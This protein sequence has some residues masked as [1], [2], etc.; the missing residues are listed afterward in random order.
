MCKV[1]MLEQSVTH[2]WQQ[3]KRNVPNTTLDVITFHPQTSCGKD[4]NPLCQKLLKTYITLYDTHRLDHQKQM[5][6]L[7][8]WFRQE[9]L[10]VPFGTVVFQKQRGGNNQVCFLCEVVRCWH[11]LA[12]IFRCHE[13]ARKQTALVRATKRASLIP[14]FNHACS[15]RDYHRVYVVARLLSG[16]AVGPKRRQCN[17]PQLSRPASPEWIAYLSQLGPAG[18]CNAQMVPGPIFSRMTAKQFYRP[19]LSAVNMQTRIIRGF[20]ITCKSNT[21]GVPVLPGPHH[22]RYGD[23]SWTP[24][25]NS[26]LVVPALVQ[27]LFQTTLTFVV[28]FGS[29]WC[30]FVLTNV[31]LLFGTSAPRQ[32]SPNTTEN[33]DAPASGGSIPW[34]SVGKAFYSAL[35]NAR[36]DHSVRDY[37]Y[38]YQSGRSRL[39]PLL[40]KN[41][42]GWRLRRAKLSFVRTGLDIANAFPSPTHASLLQR[43]QLSY[44]WRDRHFHRQ[45]LLEAIMEIEASDATFYVRCGSGN[46]Q[47]DGLAAW[48]FTDVYHPV[49]DQWHQRVRD[50]SLQVTDPV[51]QRSV[52]LDLSSYADDVDLVQVRPT[53]QPLQSVSISRTMSLHR[54]WLRSE[55]HKMSA[56]KITWY[57]T[58]ERTVVKRIV[59]PTFPLCYLVRLR[60]FTRIWACFITLTGQTCQRFRHGCLRPNEGTTQ[61]VHSGVF[62]RDKRSRCWTFFER[63]CL[64]SW[65]RGW[66]FWFCLQLRWPLCRPLSVIWGGNCCEEPRVK[67]STDANGEKTYR[68]LT[69]ATSVGKTSFRTTLSRTSHPQTTILSTTREEGRSIIDKVLQQC[70]GSIRLNPNPPLLQMAQCK[71]QTHG[72]TNS[73]RI[74]KTC[75]NLIQQQNFCAV[76]LRTNLSLYLRSFLQPSVKWIL[77][78]FV[79]AFCRCAFSL[80]SMRLQRYLTHHLFL[81]LLTLY[82]RHSHV[83]V[84]SQ[85][86]GHAISLDKTQRGWRHTCK[87][88]TPLCLRRPGRPSPMLVR[89]A[90]EFVQRYQTLDITSKTT[91]DRGHCGKPR[92]SFTVGT[93]NPP[94][95]LVCPTCSI[96]SPSLSALLE[97]IRS[98]FSHVART[99]PAPEVAPI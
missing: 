15:V 76:S 87:K 84:Y 63:W 39:D 10:S 22:L 37:A 95:S 13:E 48:Q 16:R 9:K 57:V 98:H 74:W 54:C 1:H 64:T 99:D 36:H 44:P 94:S 65:C 50:P 18:G 32:S 47:G 72:W 33:V 41:I 6:Q 30:L 46:L 21:C 60:E 71:N 38:A 89:G 86:D 40:H 58:K 93:V 75:C 62:L 26:P 20:G 70:S 23:N 42:T 68:T 91:L 11:A 56:S 5:L 88:L 61:W 90:L 49:I 19:L 79:C 80:P 4:F 66:K 28:F 2:Y 85:M 12:K 77:R 81:Q 35:G 14:E 17:I 73:L 8:K 51:S 97:C 92:G 82:Y 3:W 27:M 31:C 34:T 25:G 55:W 59:T 24:L 83:S 7:R 53:P 43:I 69:N 78:S 67:K 29:F 52:P 96:L 45:R